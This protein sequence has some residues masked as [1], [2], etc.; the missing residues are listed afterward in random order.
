[1]E[2]NWELFQAYFFLGVIK[3]G[4]LMFHVK[5]L[6]HRTLSTPTLRITWLLCHGHCRV[7]SR[8]S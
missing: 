4:Y 5:C 6:V 3:T 7:S 2:R 8:H 1:M